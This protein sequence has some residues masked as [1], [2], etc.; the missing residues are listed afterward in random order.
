MNSVNRLGFGKIVGYF[1]DNQGNKCKDLPKNC[2]SLK[3]TNPWGNHRA[4]HS[5]NVVSI[6]DE[7][8]YPGIVLTK[9]DGNSKVKITEQ[10]HVTIHELADK[11]KVTVDFCSCVN[12]NKISG[13]NT[14][15]K[16]IPKSGMEH[17]SSVNIKGPARFNFDI[18]D[19]IYSPKGVPKLEGNNLQIC[20]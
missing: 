14:T 1:T 13:E 16:V 10:S 5:S 9:V 7:N 18:R 12:I 6:D 8:C 2:Q 15:I 4:T 19:R 3:I 20:L 17:P 11:A